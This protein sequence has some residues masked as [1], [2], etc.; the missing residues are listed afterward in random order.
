VSH[1]HRR[2]GGHFL[3]RKVGAVIADWLMVVTGNATAAAA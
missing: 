1:H 3:Q 2:A